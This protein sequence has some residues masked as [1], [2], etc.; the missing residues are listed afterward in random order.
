MKI[1]NFKYIFTLFFFLIFSQSCLSQNTNATMQKN[2]I[3]LYEEIII[4]TPQDEY[5]YRTNSTRLLIN[6]QNEYF[7]LLNRGNWEIESH[8]NYEISDGEIVFHNFLIRDFGESVVAEFEKVR[9]VLNIQISESEYEN[10]ENSANNGLKWI[11][12]EKEHI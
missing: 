6:S 5:I 12:I 10:N 2:L 4:N 8:G 11:F 9:N 1:L 7:L 3:G